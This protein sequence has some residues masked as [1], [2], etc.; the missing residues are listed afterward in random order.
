[1]RRLLVALAAAFA[2]LGV[3]TA[4]AAPPPAPVKTETA[5]FA[6]GCFWCM[7]HDMGGIPGVLKVESG[8]TGGHVK[9]PSYRD[10]TSEQSG[11]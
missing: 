4:L 1:M 3:D 8:Y 5:V 7:E 2:L 6:G 11:H 10:V 9:N